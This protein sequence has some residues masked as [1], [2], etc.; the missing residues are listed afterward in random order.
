[1]YGRRL[2]DNLRVCPECGSHLRLTAPERLTQL[3]DEGSVELFDVTVRLDNPLGFVDSKPYPDR[4]HGARR[5]TGLDEGVLV[6]RGR[7]DG[8]PVIA[9]VMDFRFLGGSLGG[10]VGELITLAGEAALRERTPLL[11][12]T[13]SGGARMQEGAV[14]L[15]QM[16]KTSQMLGQ[17]DQA[18][19]LTVSLITDPTYGGV[20][21]SFATLT[22]VIVAEPGA[23]LGFAGPRVIAQTIK[24]RLPEG[25]QTAELLLKQGLIDTITPRH[26]LRQTLGRLLSL[27]TRRGGEDVRSVADPVVTDTT[28]LPSVVPWDAVQRARN[29]GRPTTLDYLSRA[30]D[31][32]EELRGD[33]V[34]GDCLAIVGG[35]ARLGDNPVVV[36]GHQKGHTPAE[37]AERNY[38]MARPAGYR[39]AARLARLAA[40][41]DLPVVTFVDTPGAYPG[42]D[43][44]EAGQSIAI[45]EMI[46]LM[47]GLP[48]PVVTVITGE[49]GS[50]GALALAVADRVLISANGTYSVISPE[51][52]AAILWNDPAA[53]PRAAEAL[54]VDARQ[55][56]A[57]GIVDGVVPEPPGG[58]HTD[59]LA[60]AEYVHDALVSSLRQLAEYDP[61]RLV[62]LRHEKFRRFGADL[63]FLRRTRNDDQ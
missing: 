26:A 23:R 30:F 40:K 51:G 4:W 33:R 39:L 53:A 59:H 29:L 31:D 24:Q 54:H 20:A 50:G 15:M 56:L 13:A 12:V 9:A 37:L 62:A 27:G 2:A 57:E 60:A 25:F 55:L 45:A 58:A 17:L 36:I 22:D 41:L 16:A 49:G 52:C 46:R 43:A 35:V 32:F 61:G 34:S 7:I 42:V 8:N 63:V 19:I 44:E 21:A 10:A 18:G 28:E 48:V 5:G 47:S 3:M 1:V 6:A 11:L 14:S 38:G